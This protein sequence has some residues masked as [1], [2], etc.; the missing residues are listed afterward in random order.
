VQG[1]AEG[2]IEKVEVIGVLRVLEQLYG[3][4]VR[5]YSSTQGHSHVVYKKTIF[6]FAKNK[7]VA[8]TTGMR[9]G[10]YQVTSTLGEGGMGIVFR[11]FIDPPCPL[12]RGTK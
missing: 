4:L 3:D 11:R 5:S 8:L 9:I 10:P 6:F 2:A 7:R 1:W 12:C